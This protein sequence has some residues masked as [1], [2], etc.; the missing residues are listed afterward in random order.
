MLS[1]RKVIGLGGA[2]AALTALNTCTGMFGDIPKHEPTPLEQLVRETTE[3]LSRGEFAEAEK[4]LDYDYDHYYDDAGYCAFRCIAQAGNRNYDKS[5]TSFRSLL[6]LFESSPE[7]VV[8][9]RDRLR[10]IFPSEAYKETKNKLKRFAKLTFPVDLTD[11][12]VVDGFLSLAE[13]KFDEAITAFKNVLPKYNNK[14][15]KYK[16]AMDTLVA[17]SK[18]ARDKIAEKGYR[19][20]ADFFQERLTQHL[21]VV[22]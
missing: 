1:R 14:L 16:K 6:N 20:V 12:W 13:Y 5:N 22:K 21:S 8:T 11:L 4:K 19:Q 10:P 9:V 15:Q 2:V 18:R 7:I 3:H 17:Y